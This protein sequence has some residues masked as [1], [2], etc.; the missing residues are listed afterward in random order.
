M[1]VSIHDLCYSSGEEIPQDYAPIVAS[2]RKHGPSSA[3][4][5]C[6]SNADTIQEAIK[7][8]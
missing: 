4:W 6:H 3:E 7:I 5:T 1:Y 2:N 8:L